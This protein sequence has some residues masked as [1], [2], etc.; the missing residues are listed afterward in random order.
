MSLIRRGIL[1][2]VLGGLT[3]RGRLSEG[4]VAL[5]DGEGDGVCS[6]TEGVVLSGVGVAAGSGVGEL[7]GDAAGVASG[8]GVAAG[9]GS[10]FTGS[11]VGEVCTEGG[12]GVGVGPGVADAAGDCMLSF[13]DFN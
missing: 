10:V 2:Q 5:G 11:G 6:G 3:R 4:G 1:S 7:S 12:S 8:V 13:S 9:E